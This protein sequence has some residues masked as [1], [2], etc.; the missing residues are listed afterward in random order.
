MK[1]TTKHTFYRNI[2]LAQIYM[3]KPY[4]VEPLEIDQSCDKSKANRLLLPILWYV[5]VQSGIAMGLATMAY[6]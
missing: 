1:N 6:N 4:R 2:E 5:H 3:A